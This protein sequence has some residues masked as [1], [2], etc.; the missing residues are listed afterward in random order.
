MA[1]MGHYSLFPLFQIF[2]IK[3]PPISAKAYGTTTSTSIDGVC[4]RVNNKDAFPYSCMFKLKFPKQESLPAFDLYWYDGGMKPFEPEELEVDNYQIEAEGLMF[5]G[6]NGKILAGFQGANPRILPS[7]NMQAYPGKKKVDEYKEERR[8]D[9]WVRAIK[10]DTESPG[11]FLEAACITETINL[12]AVALRA[13]SSVEFDSDQ[14]K[15]TN[16]DSANKFLTRE[17][18]KGWELG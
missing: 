17:Y 15:I 6:D 9:T 3:K 14:M 16:S 11:S 5:V 1:D 13:G 2:G 7:A 8:S 4:K 18:R 12:A 10:T